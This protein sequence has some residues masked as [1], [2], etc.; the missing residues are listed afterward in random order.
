MINQEVD[1]D[2]LNNVMVNFY[3][4]FNQFQDVSKNRQNFTVHPKQ[5][6][7]LVRSLH[8]NYPKE[9][10]GFLVHCNIEAVK[11]FILQI[12]N[13]YPELEK[14]NLS[15]KIWEK[16]VRVFPQDFLAFLQLPELKANNLILRNAIYRYYKNLGTTN[17]SLKKYLQTTDNKKSIIYTFT[18]VLAKLNKLNCES[19]LNNKTFKIQNNTIKQITIN[20]VNNEIEL[21]KMLI[22][23]YMN[24]QE[25]LCIL[26]FTPFDCKHLNSIKNLIDN[27]EKRLNFPQNTPKKILFIIHVKKFLSNVEYKKEEIE[28]YILFQGNLISQIAPD[29]EQ[30]TIDNLL[31]EDDDVNILDVI[32]KNNKDLF[33]LSNTNN[34]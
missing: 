12:L 23:F 28:P 9:V 16:L 19:K 30:I 2:F 7:I 33:L 22:D 13:D 14:H 15:L 32:T 34:N 24:I 6:T 21:E 11:V 4:K 18:S 5:V 8:I 17:A 1:K 25:N 31:S 20:S 10:P 26:K 3:K 27:L 29:Y